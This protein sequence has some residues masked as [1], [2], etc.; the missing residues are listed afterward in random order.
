[1]VPVRTA[2]TLAHW[3]VVLGGHVHDWRAPVRSDQTSLPEPRQ[4]P[5][6]SIPSIVPIPP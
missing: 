6:R 2:N 1:M 4:Q 3:N 5:G